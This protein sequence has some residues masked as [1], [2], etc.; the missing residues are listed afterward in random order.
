MSSL[1]SAIILCYLGVIGAIGITLS[2]RAKTSTDYFMAG[3]SIPGWVVGFSLIV[4]WVARDRTAVRA[5]LTLWGHKQ[6]PGTT[7]EHE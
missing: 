5:E 3:R 4:A 1:D 2:R 7:N 6:K